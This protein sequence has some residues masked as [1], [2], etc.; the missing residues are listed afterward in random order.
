VTNT[1]SPRYLDVA[2]LPVSSVETRY[3]SFLESAALSAVLLSTESISWYAEII[4][5]PEL[6]KQ[7]LTAPQ[8]I[9]SCYFRVIRMLLVIVMVHMGW[10]PHV[11]LGR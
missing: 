7:M 5:L 2:A 1:D 10:V 8:N 3:G 9:H 4:P 6:E 11:E